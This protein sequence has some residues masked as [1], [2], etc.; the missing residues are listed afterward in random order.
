VY[1]RTGLEW[2]AK[3]V[4][5][6]FYALY[7]GWKRLSEYNLAA[8]SEDNIQYATAYGTP[9]WYTLN[10]RAS[11][12]FSRNVSLQMGLENIQDTNYRTFASGVSAPGRNFQVSLR[13][14]F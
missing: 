6:E 13:A 4:H 1:G 8:G 14:N 10:V 5:A 12:A 11:Y 9:T 7:N 3:K 2:R